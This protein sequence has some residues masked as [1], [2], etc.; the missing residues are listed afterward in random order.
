M[1]RAGLRD[2]AKVSACLSNPYRTR[3][4]TTADRGHYPDRPLTGSEGKGVWAAGGDWRQ[5]PPRTHLR[6]NFRSW[7]RSSPLCAH[8]LLL[9]ALPAGGGASR[10]RDQGLGECVRKE[11]MRLMQV[12]VVSL[13]LAG[14]AANPFSTDP[15]EL[16]AAARS[17]VPA[18]ASV[19]ASRDAGCV[20]LRS[21]PS[22]VIISLE[23]VPASWRARERAIE[24]TADASGWRRTERRGGEG[25][26]LLVYERGDLR[27]S[28]SVSAREYFWRRHCQGRRPLARED[29]FED[30]A[31]LI[32][33]IVK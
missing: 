3:I 14:C 1:S 32:R 29:F 15:E 20:E 11:G 16:R 23:V 10:T 12:V 24:R 31:D 8:N 28:V 9:R 33:V 27:A 26:T 30:C 17:L 7:R 19:G 25:G 2:A 13:L 4:V 21:F 18:G 22:C 5:P 6:R